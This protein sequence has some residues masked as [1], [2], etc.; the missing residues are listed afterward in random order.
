MSVNRTIPSVL[1]CAMLVACA[2]P[3]VIPTGPVTTPA[4]EA[5]VAAAAVTP[6][7]AVDAGSASAAPSASPA[8]T[9]SPSP[10]P[11]RRGSRDRTP[12]PIYQEADLGGLSVGS[13][14]YAPGTTV[15]GVI[16]GTATMAIRVDGRTATVQF[17]ETDHPIQSPAFDTVRV[18]E[19]DNTRTFGADQDFGTFWIHAPLP[20]VYR[21]RQVEDIGEGGEE[22]G[23]DVPD[24]ALVIRPLPEGRY[25][26][27]RGLMGEHYIAPTLLAAAEECVAWQE[28]E[29]ASLAGLSALY[30]VIREGGS[31]Y[32]TESPLAAFRALSLDRPLAGSRFPMSPNLK[33]D[34]G[35]AQILRYQLLQAESEALNPAAALLQE[36][37]R[38]RLEDGP[39]VDL[40]P[41]E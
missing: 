18:T 10:T 20:L 40:P 16:Q 4:A 27:G 22:P 11:R 26:I 13:F 2:A 25:E 32:S 15:D 7:P 3:S 1:L 33:K 5:P 9:P 14:S 41:E 31:T 35:R 29:G 36:I 24:D 37:I 39:V 19:G 12:Q 30:T 17:E 8:A 6:T 38:L 21:V 28:F 34:G 23:A